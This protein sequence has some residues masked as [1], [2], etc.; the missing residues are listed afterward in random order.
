MITFG[1]VFFGERAYRFCICSN[2]IG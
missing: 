2:H 1:Y